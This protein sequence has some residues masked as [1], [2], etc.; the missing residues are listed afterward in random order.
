[1]TYLKNELEKDKLNIHESDNYEINYLF[2]IFSKGVNMTIDYDNLECIY[3]SNKNN[4]ICGK[5]IM[6]PPTFN[7]MFNSSKISF[8]LFDFEFE[9]EDLDNTKLLFKTLHTILEDKFKMAQL[10]IEPCLTQIRK[11]LEQKENELNSKEIKNN[12]HNL[13]Q[14]LQKLLKNNLNLNPNNAFIKSDEEYNQNNNNKQDVEKDN[15]ILAKE[16]SGTDIIDNTHDN[17]YDNNNIIYDNNTEDNNDD[18]IIQTIEMEAQEINEK[19][20]PEN[21]LKEANNNKKMKKGKT[22][23][24]PITNKKGKIIESDKEINKAV[25]DN[26]TNDNKLNI[27]MRNEEFTNIKSTSLNTYNNSYELKEPSNKSV[28]NKKSV[29]KGI[30][31]VNKKNN[32]K[33]KT[34]EIPYDNKS[35]KKPEDNIIQSKNGSGQCEN[36]KENKFIKNKPNSSTNKRSKNDSALSTSNLVNKKSKIP[37]KQSL[38]KKHPQVV[39]EPHNSKK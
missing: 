27:I 33:S 24:N 12:Y 13:E 19:D 17:N 6:P 25:E 35:K 10:L 29:N 1:M 31:N 28:S 36:K 14:N 5:A 2:S 4:K 21:I 11:E 15:Q 39:K 34:I 32:I 37:T 20:L 26:N 3:Y 30:T 7:L 9:I 22:N 16:K 18:E 8:K 38:K 23:H